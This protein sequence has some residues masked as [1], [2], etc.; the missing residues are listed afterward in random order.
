MGNTT[1]KKFGGREKGTKN[2]VESKTKQ[3]LKDLI[4]DNQAKIQKELEKLE[5][6]DYLQALDRLMEYTEP[7]LSRTEVKAEIEDTTRRIGY[8][9][10]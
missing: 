10:D 1:G 8:D 4:D 5:G 9:K 7:K 6:K 2:K 3:F